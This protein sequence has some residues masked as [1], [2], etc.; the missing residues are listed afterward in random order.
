MAQCL[1]L[2]FLKDTKDLKMEKKDAEDDRRSGKSSTCE[3]DEN[4]KRMREKVQSDRCL[5]VRMIAGEMLGTISERMWRIITED[6]R[7]IGTEAAE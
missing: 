2:R 6:L 5:A 7:F 4:V 1:E 3:T